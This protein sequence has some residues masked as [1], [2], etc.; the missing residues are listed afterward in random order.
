ME[1]LQKKYNSSESSTLPGY[2]VGDTDI[3]VFF[4]IYFPYLLCES[5][6]SDGGMNT[7]Q[8]SVAKKM[9]NISIEQKPKNYP[10]KHSF[11]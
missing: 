9:M 10:P 4:L 3:R 1:H 5:T 6:M 8:N 7:K 11:I 2:S